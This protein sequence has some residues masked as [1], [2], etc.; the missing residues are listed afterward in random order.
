[1]RGASSVTAGTCSA[2]NPHEHRCQ[3]VAPPPVLLFRDEPYQV[4][5][6]AEDHRVH[7]PPSVHA[8]LAVPAAWL[9]RTVLPLPLWQ[10]TKEDQGAIDYYADEAMLVSI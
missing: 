2:L 9:L 5:H 4:D 1:M 7:P 3:G 8:A 10:K 6:S